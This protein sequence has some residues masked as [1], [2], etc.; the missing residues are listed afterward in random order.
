[1]NRLT[2][3]RLIVAVMM[4]IASAGAVAGQTGQ[5]T[6]VDERWL[7]WIGCWRPSVQRA[8][9]EGVHVCVVPATSG[10]VRILT[11]AGDRTLVDDTIVGDGVVRS[12]DEPDCTGTR[13]AEWSSDGLRLYSNADVTC[14]KEA[15]KI[16]GMT[17]LSPRAEWIDVQ[18]VAAGNRESV[19]VRRY[20]RSTDAPPD[21]STIPADLAAR[22]VRTALGSP[23]TIEHIKEASSKVSPRVLEA[24]LFETKSAFPI[25][26]RQLIAM[27]DAGVPDTVIDVMVAF[28]FPEKF[29]VKRSSYGSG[30]FGGFGGFGWGFDGDAD[31]LWHTPYYAFFSP[32]GMWGYGFYDDYFFFPGT[33][34]I[35]PGGGGST[36][37]G[38]GRVINGAGY[39]QVVRRAPES[40]DSANG[41]TRVRGAGADAGGSSVGNSSGGSS[42]VSS[43][44]YSSGGGG[45]G[46]TAVP[47]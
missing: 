9:E 15:R 16:S 1:M 30:G 5:A 12:I 45:S 39:T 35:V 18:V 46:R 44:G 34:V 22:S 6:G 19:R 43:G 14:E 26:S 11:L 41:G 40:T 38:H 29:E 2:N 23:L 8:P 28:T 32:F 42:G 47:R 3:R 36:G 31:Y 4:V 37:E 27:S 17:L 25:D 10:G 7:P 33:G 13:R 21:P 24:L 20:Q